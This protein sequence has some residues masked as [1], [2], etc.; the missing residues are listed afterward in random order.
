M[1][2]LRDEVI[3]LAGNFAIVEYEHQVRWRSV[4]ALGH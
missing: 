3:E 1:R 4:S 2:A